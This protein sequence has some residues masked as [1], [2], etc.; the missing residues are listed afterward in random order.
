MQMDFGTN[1]FSSAWN[2]QYDTLGQLSNAW[3]T[4][5][6][7]VVPGRQYGYQFDDIGNRKQT[8]RGNNRSGLLTGPTP[9]VT[10]DYTANLLNQYSQR[11]V[12]AYAEISGTA[13][14][15]AILSFR[16]EDTG[17]RIRAGRNADWFHAFMLL[18]DNYITG[19]TNA[20]RMTAVLPGQGASGTD[21]INTNQTLA[22]SAMKTPEIFDFDDDGNLLSDGRFTYTWNAENRLIQVS[23]FQF[24]VSYAYDHQGRRV[25]KQLY[26]LITNNWELITETKFL[27]NGNHI[28]SEICCDPSEMQTNVS[29]FVW[30][31]NGQLVSFVTEAQGLEPQA[32]FYCH[33]GNKNVTDLVNASGAIVAHYEYDPF[34]NVTVKTGVLA[35]ENPFRFSNEY[36]DPETGHVAYMLRYLNASAGNW[37]NRDPLGERGGLNL[38]GMVGNDPVDTVD[39]LGLKKLS[40][41]D[42]VA[43]LQAGLSMLEAACDKGCKKRFLGIFKRTCCTPRVCKKEAKQIIQSLIEAWER[44]YGNGPYDDSAPGSDTVGGYFCW[45]WSHIFENALANFKPDCVSFEQGMAAAPATAQGTPVH[46]YLMVHACKKEKAECRVNFDDGYF[47]GQ[48]SS[49]PG[50]FPDPTSPYQPT[51]PIVTPTWPPYVPITPAPPRVR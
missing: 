21:L 26:E 39:Y 23:N 15:D 16:N 29:S 47:D 30:G 43:A 6:G 2:Y 38:Y 8:T 4:A 33:D 49:H 14:P 20:V 11:T 1:G 50:T 40:K 22:L 34:G 37:L 27:W 28:I 7:S 32:F 17:T 10:S 45:D 35:D 18:T 3:K 31:N 5:N 13:N 25:Q 12:P 9:V 51:P 24:Q 42:G 48:N 19:T 44:N 46:W 36:Y 41:S